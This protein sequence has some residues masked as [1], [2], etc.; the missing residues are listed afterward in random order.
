MEPRP[1]APP[2]PPS[3]PEPPK[4]PAPDARTEER[5][6]VPP[7]RFVDGFDEERSTDSFRIPRI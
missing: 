1:E 6:E 4:P 3:P 2:G 7:E 5:K